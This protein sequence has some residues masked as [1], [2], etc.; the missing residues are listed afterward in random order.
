[1]YV[2]V[3]IFS[4]ERL[5]INSRGI[6]KC[7]VS[8]YNQFRSCFMLFTRERERER[9]NC[10]SSKHSK[11]R[12]C[13]LVILTVTLIIFLDLIFLNQGQSKAYAS[14]YPCLSLPGNSS[15]PH[16]YSSTWLFESCLLR[17]QRI[18]RRC[19]GRYEQ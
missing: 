19:T 18:H 17:N 9:I 6:E 5:H 10:L 14:G 2:K 11:L 1:M 7:E 13:F 8:C 3:R 12:L 15:Q 4:L 16:G